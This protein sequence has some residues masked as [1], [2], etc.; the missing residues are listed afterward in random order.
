MRDC[1]TKGDRVLDPFLGSGT[2]ILAAEKIG[3]KAYGLE[4][5]PKFVDATIR[6]WEAYTKSEAILDGDGRTYA[7]VKADRLKQAAIS[8]AAANATG[9]HEPAADEGDWVALCESNTS[10]EPFER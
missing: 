5:E 6:R 8:P 2:T 10:G 7:E 9:L 1:T 3:R 4:L